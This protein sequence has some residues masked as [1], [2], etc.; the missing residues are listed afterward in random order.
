VQDEEAVQRFPNTNHH[1]EEQLGMLRMNSQFDPE[2]ASWLADGK[3]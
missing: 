2:A 3:S 1:L